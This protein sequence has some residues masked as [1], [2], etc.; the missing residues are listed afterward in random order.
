MV[1]SANGG[2]VGSPSLPLVHLPSTSLSPLLPHGPGWT[3]Q[4]NLLPEDSAPL[5]QIR[6]KGNTNLSVLVSFR[7]R[8]TGQPV[9]LTQGYPSKHGIHSSPLGL[10]TG[11]KISSIFTP[12]EAPFYFFPTTHVLILR[13]SPRFFS[14]VHP[15]FTWPTLVDCLG[16][17]PSIGITVML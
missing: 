9:G 15:P 3:S 5:P 11:P 4:L 10:K 7:L 16:V 14:W 8:Q 17:S 2:S 12:V 1:G 13:F 6:P